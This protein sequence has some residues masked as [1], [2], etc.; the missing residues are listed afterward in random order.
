VSGERKYR[1]LEER[2]MSA[3][4]SQGGGE[5][6]KVVCLLSLGCGVW[7][8][9]RASRGGGGGRRGTAELRM[10]SFAFAQKSSCLFSLASLTPPFP[11]SYI[12]CFHYCCC[13]SS[14][15]RTLCRSSFSWK[16]YCS[17]DLYDFARIVSKS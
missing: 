8:G 3:E 12:L 2:S 9:S 10:S 14:V 1:S 6:A 17:Y 4:T 13:G 5:E 7:G 16:L 15:A 11:F